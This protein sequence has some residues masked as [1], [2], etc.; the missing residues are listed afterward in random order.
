MQ[1]FLN[2]IIIIQQNFKSYDFCYN[3]FVLQKSLSEI[4]NVINLLNYNIKPRFL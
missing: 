1:L 2:N 4:T 3:F